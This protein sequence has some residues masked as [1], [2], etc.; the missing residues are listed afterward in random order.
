MYRK[1][2]KKLLEW[3]NALERKPLMLLG[4]RQVGKTYIIEE[5][6]KKNFD[7]Y[8][9][10]NLDKEENMASIFESTIDPD[11]IIE[12]IEIIKNININ[13]NSLKFILR[14]IYKLILNR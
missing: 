10:I 8:V 1:I 3:K 13:I 9:Y 6:C 2:Y 11:K 5:F 4:A 12:M 7:N 14:G